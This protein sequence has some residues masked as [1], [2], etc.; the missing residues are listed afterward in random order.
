MTG[1]VVPT[2]GIPQPGPAGTGTASPP[3]PSGVAIGDVV[4]GQLPDSLRV[5]IRPIVL[6][7]TVAGLEP[8]GQ[9]RLRT[10]QGELTFRA[11]GMVPTDR[12]ITLQIAPGQ[13]PTRAMAFIAAVTAGR[14]SVQALTSSAPSVPAPSIQTSAS[15]PPAPLP[16]LQPGT[17]LQA[18]VATGGLSTMIAPQGRI[19]TGLILD[20]LALTATMATTARPTPTIPQSGQTAGQTTIAGVKSTPDAPVTG[21]PLSGGRP[22]SP[23][24]P[25]PPTVQPS[26]A[27]LAQALGGP[28]ASAPLASTNPGILP[29]GSTLTVQVVGIAGPGGTINAALSNTDGGR[30]LIG[31]VAGVSRAGNPIVATPQGTLILQSNGSLP[32]GAVVT[33]ATAPATATVARPIGPIPP[34]IPSGGAWPALAEAL[35]TLAEADPAIA[36]SL[37]N[38]TIPRATPQI[39]STLLFFM[40]ALRLGDARHWIGERAARALETAGRGDILDRLG[41]DF[42][43]LGRQAADPSAGDWRSY[44]VPLSDG[45]QLS[46]LHLYLRHHRDEEAGNDD[47]RA[48]RFVIDVELSRLGPLQLDGLVKDRRFDLI[49]RSRSALEPAL[50]DELTEAFKG[51]L[52]ATGFTGTLVFQ[53][54][55]RNWVK[56]RPG[57][58]KP[59][60]VA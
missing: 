36:Q 21:A 40:A 43:L 14:P 29:Q 8:D 45:G 10:P 50:K 2:S 35:D 49:L 41:E 33:L 28:S 18:Q 17:I 32:T 5:L 58:G 30:L 53:T 13:P 38:T 6:T 24:P 57:S 44:Y 46:Y 31:T 9:V 27:L 60:V 16:P 52:S 1:P 22:A 54:D 15:I 37:L 7:G 55:E 4:L 25:S 47:G 11:N 26:A 19:T 12:P 34:L 48:N 59:G 20:D 42:R 23:S 56:L 51:G 39:A 3:L